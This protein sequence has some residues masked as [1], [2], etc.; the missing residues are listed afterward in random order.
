MALITPVTFLDAMRCD[1]GN[2]AACTSIQVYTVLFILAF[3]ILPLLF[4]LTSKKS[5]SAE[6]KHMYQSFFPSK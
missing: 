2:E 4:S 6:Y 1:K 5:I 3:L